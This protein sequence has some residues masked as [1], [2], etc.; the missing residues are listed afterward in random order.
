MPKLRVPDDEL[1][2]KELEDAEYT[3]GSG[4]YE[5]YE[6]PEPGGKVL[7]PLYIKKLW[8]CYTS[9]ED[10]M[11]K[12]L[13]I[14]DDTAGRFSGWP[15]WD[16]IALTAGAKFRWQPFLDAFGFT[17]RDIKGKIMV[18]EE[19]DLGD[20]IEKIGTWQPGEDQDGAYARVLTKREKYQG[21][22]ST[23]ID[24]WLKYKA[25]VE[26][27]DSDEEEE[28]PARSRSRSSSD[29]K[30]KPKPRAKEKPEPEPDDEQDDEDEPDE[31]PAKTRG[32]SRSAKGADAAGKGRGT[33]RKAATAKPAAKGRGR[34]ATDD[35]EDEPPF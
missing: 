14:A 2:V 12:V 24:T 22:W 28:P 26:G 8:W 17:L 16:N 4:D 29:G 21:N 33:A 34:A 7:V 5:D 20:P 35:D 11:I 27:D 25:G 15:V 23:K 19:E 10:P 9:N 31:P 18:G 6:G 30:A 13:A 32:T 1:D 3:E